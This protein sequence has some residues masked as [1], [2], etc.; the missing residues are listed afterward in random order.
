M[1]CLVTGGAGF[2]GSHIADI[3]IKKGEEVS[4][5]DNLSTGKIKNLNKKAIFY[6]EDI[7]N[8][9]A[10]EKMFEKEKLD[11][12]FHTA[13]QINVR[14]S[15]ENPVKDA[16]INILGTLNLLEACRKCNV[17][18][19]IFSST[20]GAIYGD[21][22]K[23]PTIET[24]K[25]QPTSPYG[26]AKLSIEKYLYFYKK[27]YGIDYVS[28]RYSN[29]YGPRQNYKGEAGV[30]A[31][32]INK[33]L[34]NKQSVINGS[35]KQTRD[36]VYV[37]DVARANLLALK[38]NGIFNVSTGKETSVNE[39]FKMLKKIMRINVEAVHGPAKKGEQKRS[40][41]DY[42]K[43]KGKGWEPKTGLEQGLEAT[44]E[45]F[46]KQKR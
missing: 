18:K 29:V 43:I 24:E 13:A 33:I 25:Q 11:Y 8:K 35:G 44:I 37:R 23:I 30:V 39:L 28:L 10:I 26:I 20:G 42:S 12:V 16:S 14:E 34:N 31:I 45:W 40:C 32:F 38:L 6:K 19:F 17:K 36:Y 27:V 41:L 46:K 3:L 15:V 21:N 7:R 9:K 1:K 2:I 4:I 22:V 5:I